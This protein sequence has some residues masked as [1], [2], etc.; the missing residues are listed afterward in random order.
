M[1]KQSDE[2]T[3]EQER[4]WRRV[5]L[6]AGGFGGVALIVLGLYWLSLGYPV[7]CWVAFAGSL[8]WIA[9]AYPEEPDD[10]ET[11]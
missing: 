4:A 3:P 11:D 1:N 2:L 5:Q 10:G 7:A 8:G 9:G 6:I